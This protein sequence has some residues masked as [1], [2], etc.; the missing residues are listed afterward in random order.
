MFRNAWDVDPEAAKRERAIP[1]VE[2]KIVSKEEIFL[3]HLLLCRLENFTLLVNEGLA[4]GERVYVVVLEWGGG[5]RR[6]K[7]FDF[8]GVAKSRPFV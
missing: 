6:L 8:Y 7:F 3:M 2:W 5:L 1:P 4:V